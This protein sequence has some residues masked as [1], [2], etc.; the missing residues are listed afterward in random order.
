MGR[1]QLYS[2]CPSLAPGAHVTPISTGSRPSV[3]LVLHYPFWV[4]YHEMHAPAMR[5]MRG[6]LGAGTFRQSLP[7]NTAEM[8]YLGDAFRYAPE[9]AKNPRHCDDSS[10]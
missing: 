6:A 3:P 10:G 8:P 4:P 9:I 7:C 5:C 1:A 2:I